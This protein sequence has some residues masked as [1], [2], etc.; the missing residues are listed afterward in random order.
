MTD[1]LIHMLDAVRAPE[2]SAL[3]IPIAALL[4]VGSSTDAWVPDVTSLDELLLKNDREGGL[5]LVLIILNLS[6]RGFQASFTKKK[7]LSYLT[8]SW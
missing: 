4:A 5:A 7:S 2:I 3:K 1:F 6:E 8:I